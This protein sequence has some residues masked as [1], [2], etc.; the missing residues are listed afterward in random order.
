MTTIKFCG[1]TL[2]ADAEFAVELGASHVGVIF[3]ESP[4][5][6]SEITAKKVLEL[7][8][9]RV[10]HVGVFGRSSPAAVAGTANLLKLDVVQIHR[11]VDGA[12]MS[13][14]KGGYGGQV[15]LVV[16][17]DDAPT[18]IAD[19]R[20]RAQFADA[21]LLDTS[22]AGRT[23]GTGKPFAWE[24]IADVFAREPIGIPIIIAGGLNPNNVGEAIRL[25][26]PAVVDVSSGVE[27]RPGIKDHNL[28]RSFAEAVHSASIV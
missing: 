24:S 12:F 22:V 1:I 16:G 4:R 9:S 3:A 2:P 27:T 17:V 10:K 14:L 19:A 18:A 11:A 7:A 13:R 15:W 25:L 8:D 20:E 23:G 21:I 28:M 5:R 6:V 26:R